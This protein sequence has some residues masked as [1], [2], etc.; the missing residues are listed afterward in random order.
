MGF[1]KE[2]EVVGGFRVESISIE[3]VAAYI[4]KLARYEY[5]TKMI[6]KGDGTVDDVKG[7]FMKFF[8][9]EKIL[10]SSYENPYQ[11]EPGKMNVI[12]IG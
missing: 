2:G 1:P 11:C 4:D 8:I 9:G 10:L 5:P 12:F 6:V 7:A 3:H